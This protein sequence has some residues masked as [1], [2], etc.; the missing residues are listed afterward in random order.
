MGQLF[1]AER[2]LR[3]AVHLVRI[4]SVVLVGRQGAVA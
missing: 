2:D 4:L 1:Y 3:I